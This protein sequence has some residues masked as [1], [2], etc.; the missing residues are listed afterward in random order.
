MSKITC[1]YFRLAHT[2]MDESQ[3]AADNLSGTDTL[4]YRSITCTYLMQT[5]SLSHS[6][7][8]LDTEESIISSSLIPL[9]KHVQLHLQ[10]Y[11]SASSRVYSSSDTENSSLLSKIPLFLPKHHKMHSVSSDNVLPS[12]GSSATPL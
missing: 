10:K 8:C 7:P 6:N 9:P 5:Y 2:G 11:E 3:L 4:I 12:E 1:I